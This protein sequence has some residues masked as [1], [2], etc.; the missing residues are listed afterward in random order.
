MCIWKWKKNGE[1]NYLSLKSVL[2][3]MGLLTTRSLTFRVA[4]RYTYPRA[5]FYHIHSSAVV[6]IARWIKANT[7]KLNRKQHWFFS[8]EKCYC[9]QCSES[10]IIIAFLNTIYIRWNYHLLGKFLVLLIWK[11]KRQFPFHLVL[12]FLPNTVYISICL[13]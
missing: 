4:S 12:S 7:D 11:V 5:N 10:R 8:E 1:R 9:I 3:V 13:L 2:S 6:L